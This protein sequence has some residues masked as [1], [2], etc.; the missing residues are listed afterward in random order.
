MRRSGSRKIG[1]AVVFLGVLLAGCTSEPAPGQGPSPASGPAAAPS[2]ALPAIPPP[3]REPRDIRPFAA[4]ACELLTP[5]QVANLGYGSRSLG[6]P[7]GSRRDA[8]CTWYG[9]EEGARQLG[10][11]PFP[12]S[13]VLDEVYDEPHLSVPT[14]D[15]SDSGTF[16]TAE[17][18]EV[19]GYPA[20][21][22]K[23]FSSSRDCE[24][25][26]RIASTQGFQVHSF[27]T[28]GAQPMNASELQQWPRWC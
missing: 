5:A 18:V 21:A 15:G 17:A 23:A 12:D 11:T 2:S 4:R 9:N 20:V 19:S 22:R 1:S 25:T 10:L 24:L 7:L 28:G 16:Q 14:P 27:G 13:S 6:S 8:A 3:I 26:V